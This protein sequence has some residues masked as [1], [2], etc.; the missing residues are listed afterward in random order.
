MSSE[1]V[2]ES[3]CLSMLK[4]FF[5]DLL[6]LPMFLHCI[7]LILFIV[8]PTVLCLIILAMRV[9]SERVVSVVYMPVCPVC[10]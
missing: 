7:T 8:M 2:Y 4:P 6:Y 5:I 3:S 10:L 1:Q 9:Y